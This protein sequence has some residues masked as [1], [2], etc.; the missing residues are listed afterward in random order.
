MD[1]SDQTATKA[2]TIQPLEHFYVTGEGNR[3]AEGVILPS[4]AF[5]LSWF[6]EGHTHGTYPSLDVFRQIQAGMS[7]REIVPGDR[8]FQ[9]GQT[10]PP[11]AGRTFYLQRNEDYNGISGTGKVAIGFEFEQITVV[12]WLSAEGSTFWYKSVE[13]V[14]HIHGHDGRTLV[15]RVTEEND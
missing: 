13:L 7:G 1:S 11:A 5:A 6:G 8:T 15:V 3:I 12:Q 2:K 9:D 14:E 10:H 4:G